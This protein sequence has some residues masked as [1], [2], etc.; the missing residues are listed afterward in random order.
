MKAATLFVAT[1]RSIVHSP[2]ASLSA[3]RVPIQ[4]GFF[5]EF[6]RSTKAISPFSE[7]RPSRST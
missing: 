3:V 5:G 6:P 7:K 2:K 1:S 4:A